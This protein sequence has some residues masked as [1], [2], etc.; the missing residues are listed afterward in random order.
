MRGF[1]SSR[2]S[3][4]VDKM[5]SNL[6]VFSTYISINRSQKNSVLPGLYKNEILNDI[7]TTLPRLKFGLGIKFLFIRCGK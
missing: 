6:R 3:G 4:K 5:A 1:K 7:L 2:L